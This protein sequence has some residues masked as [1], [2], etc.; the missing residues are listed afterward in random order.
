MDLAA[1]RAGLRACQ[2]RF[3]P[4]SRADIYAVHPL[5]VSFMPR[6]IVP[7]EFDKV[8]SVPLNSRQRSAPVLRG[9]E[10]SS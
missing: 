5:S 8:A 7:I 3:R 1:G 4:G 2:A 6:N 10:V 9:L